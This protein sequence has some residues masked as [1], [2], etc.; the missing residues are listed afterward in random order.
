MKRND[1]VLI[2]FT[3]PWDWQADCQRQTCLELAR[4]GTTVYAY[5]ANDAEFFLKR[6]SKI[7]SP[8]QNIH[9]IKPL[10]FIPFR[11]VEWIEKFNQR[12]SFF[13]TIANLK[14][15]NQK[16]LVW[17]FD[18]YFYWMTQYRFFTTKTIYDCVDY[19]RGSPLAPPDLA[20]QERTLIENV[21][22]FF[23]NSIILQ[24]IHRHR[25]AILVPQGCAI[26]NFKSLKHVR[27]SKNKQPVIGFIGGINN[28]INYKLLYT[29]AQSLP[30]FQWVFQ[31]S[32]T[33]YELWKPN[34]HKYFT[35]F[36]ALPNVTIRPNLPRKYMADLMRTFDVGIIPYD[37]NQL[38]NKY[39]YPMKLFEYFA[40]G[41]PVISTTI[42]ELNRFPELVVMSESAAEWQKQLLNLTAKPWSPSKKKLQLE[43]ARANSWKNKIDAILEVVES[44]H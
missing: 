16:I 30:S 34:Q 42:T 4:R 2:P 29:V 36:T 28:R 27:K 41:L 23:T 7:T 31:G 18:P 26:D 5:L 44:R 40:I 38:F 13:F 17:I 9:F 21:N 11:R 43:L 37:T 24:H 22:Y 8:H 15:R 3:L 12:L 32:N 19:H 33:Q 14:I 10:Y 1:Q 35:L 25:T 20:K 6:T 39:C